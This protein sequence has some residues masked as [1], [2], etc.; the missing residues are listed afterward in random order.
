M[1][2]S[3]N[4]EG[5]MKGLISDKILRR[6]RAK[7]RGWVFTAK[8]FLDLA[9]RNTIDQVLSRLTRKGLIRKLATGIYDFPK[10]H[11]ILG[12]LAPT[13]DAIIR[14]I[15]T[16]T[17]YSLYPSGAVCANILGLSTQVPA[18]AVYLTQGS[19]R[20]KIIGN[21]KITL[22]YD[23]YSNPNLSNKALAVIHALIN[24][25]KDHIEDS[26]IEK[27]SRQLDNKDKKGLKRIVA[28]L[29]SWIIPIVS[30]ISS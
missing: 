27:C 17:G 21:L 9:T 7:R 15:S 19:S 10:Q 18:Q 22:K 1:V 11:A 2:L 23:R 4:T 3:D 26:I 6:I 29:P 12:E 24:I 28:T 5:K 13:H 20:S 14:T 8:D 25:G 16:Q 30:Q